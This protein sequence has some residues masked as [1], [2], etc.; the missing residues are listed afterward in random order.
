MHDT[1]SMMQDIVKNPK[2]PLSHGERDRVRGKIFY[3][4]NSHMC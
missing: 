3:G 1:G 4:T 2:S